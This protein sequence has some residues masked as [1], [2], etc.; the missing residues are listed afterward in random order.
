MPLAA[1]VS[2]GAQKI[3][4]EAFEDLERALSTSDRVSLKDT[5]LD[6]VREAA[7]LVENELAARQSLRNMRRLEPLFAG[8]GYYSKT[9]EVLCNGTPYMP[10]IWAP[11]K[12]ILKISSDHIEAFEKIIKAYS[13]IAEPLQRFRYIDRA[14]S[15]DKDVQQTLAIFYSDILKFHKEAYQFVRRSSWQLL[16]LTS[17]GRFQ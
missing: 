6:D 5:T 14:F 15:K 9:I 13:Q 11:I 7:R 3:I 1:R 10:W 8:L 12:L 16:F 2:L 4:R 17:W